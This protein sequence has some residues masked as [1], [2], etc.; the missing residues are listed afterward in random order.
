MIHGPFN[1]EVIAIIFIPN[2]MTDDVKL[3]FYDAIGFAYIAL[4]SV[5]VMIWLL[6]RIYFKFP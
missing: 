4:K 6:T 3:D 1:F 5:F 2:L